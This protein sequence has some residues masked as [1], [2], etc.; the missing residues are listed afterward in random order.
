[1]A[2]FFAMQIR[3]GKI[4]IDDVP[5]RWKEATRKLVEQENDEA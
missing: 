2:K 1:M 4:A 5:E 3:L